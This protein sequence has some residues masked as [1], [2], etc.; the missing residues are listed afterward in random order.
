MSESLMSDWSWINAAADRFER[1]WKQGP[2][3]CM[4]DSLDDVDED[5]RAAL[6]E[7]LLRVECELRRRAGEEPTAEEYHRRFSGH[8]AVVD[9]VFAGAMES[10]SSAN[11]EASAG[12]VAPARVSGDLPRVGGVLAGLA[13]TIGP[14]PH[15]L[16]RDT[17]ALP[18][19]PVVHTS[20]SEM[21]KDAGR[22]QLLEEIGHGGMGLVIK[23]RDPDLGRDLAVKVLLEEH[24]DVPDLVRRFI[25]EAQIGG[26]LQHP[27]IVP[28]YELGQFGDGRPYFTMKLVRGRTLAALLAERVEAAS[29]LPRFLGIFEQVCQTVAYAHARTVI[30]RDLKPSNIMVGAFGEVLVMDWGLSKVLPP[31]GTAGEPRERDDETSVDLIRTV[32]SDSDVDASRP[33]SVMG[34]PAYMAPEQ[35]QGEIEAIDERADVFGLGSILC[36]ML[37]GRPA[38][39]GPSREVILGRASR[40]EIADAFQRIDASGA[41]PELRELT[42][43]CLSVQPER[44]SAR[45]R[46]GCGG[47]RGA[48][49]R[50]AGTA[51]S[52]RFGASRSRGPCGGGIEAAGFSRRPVARGS[53]PCRGR[54][55]GAPAGEPARPRGRGPGCR[56]AEAASDDGRAGGLGAGPGWSC[57][58]YLAGSGTIEGATAN[59]GGP[60]AG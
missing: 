38:Y 4:E 14:V 20:S 11:G 34:S 24:R 8:A 60:G 15:V 44:P 18:D 31:V 27:G 35:A 6:L 40:G 10:S 25:E 3:P 22:Y 57:R 51:S 53:S 23:G 56:G 41:D 49:Q 5:R 13:E 21:P 26:Q 55:Q 54:G 16:L 29:D 36:E 1:A 28:V 58:R 33:G 37:T 50:G 42:R 32:R 43:R 12:P 48:C 2:R 52:G 19:G 30:H 46:R 47:D 59:L 17:E 45:C 7:E 9:A 39:T